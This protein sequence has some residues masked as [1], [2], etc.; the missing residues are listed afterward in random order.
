MNIRA[1]APRDA[2]VL[3]RLRYDFRCELGTPAE[4]EP[5]FVARCT[6]WM[7][8]RLGGDRDDRWI[9]WVA[10]E[11]GAIIGNLWLQRLE[12]VPN[13][14]AEPEE[15][16]YVTNVYVIPDR[17]DVGVGAQLF[18][19]A[20]EWC[21]RSDVDAVLLWPSARSRR[22]YARYGFGTRDDLF[23]LRPV[24]TSSPP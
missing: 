9:C 11:G 13:P 19:A 24:L 6:A 18:E 20:L 8:E 12:K 2:P 22:F 16:A 5:V 4:A 14:V 7:L 3:A 21:R 17:R 15:H 23:A 10:E 1:A